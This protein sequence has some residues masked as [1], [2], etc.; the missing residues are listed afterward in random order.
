MRWP[1]RI[2][3]FLAA[4]KST[5]R[6]AHASLRR[7]RRARRATPGATVPSRASDRTRSQHCSGCARKSGVGRLE[8]DRRRPS[9]PAPPDAPVR[10]APASASPRSADARRRAPLSRARRER[11]RVGSIRID[12]AL[13]LRGGCLSNL[14]EPTPRAREFWSRDP[15]ST[16][17]RALLSR[18]VSVRHSKRRR[19]HRPG[20]ADRQAERIATARV[21]RVH[22]RLRRATFVLEQRSLVRA[23][24]TSS[25]FSGT[26]SSA[27]SRS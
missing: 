9:R 11:S 18:R 6:C 2:S 27:S 24:L 13:D 7:H 25:S 19:R 26:G 3:K 4:D 15:H 5:R 12:R 16:G 21:R 22:G 23:G 8:I 14:S 20:P 17:D 1:R 10:L